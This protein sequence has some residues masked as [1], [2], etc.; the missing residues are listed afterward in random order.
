AS[1]A[2]AIGALQYNE[3]TA[4][5]VISAGRAAGEPGRIDVNPAGA[6]VTIRNGALTTGPAIPVAVLIRPSPRGPYLDVR[7]TGPLNGVR[8]VRNVS[9]ENPTVYFANAMRR[10]LAANGIE[11]EGATVDV[12][13]LPAPIAVDGL[14]PLLVHQSAPLVNLAA[15]M[16]KMSQNLYAETLLRTLGVHD[17]GVGSFE[18]GRAA[19]QRTLAAWGISP[20]DLMI[21]DGSGLSRHNLM[22]AEALVTVLARLAADE[23]LRDRFTAALPV[24]GRDGT[25]SDRMRHTAAEG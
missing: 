6:P 25:L 22:T 14:Q 20:S 15:T 9:V 10:A 12:D 23:R 13:D 19:L 18:T 16:M 2:T 5:L 21:A 1:Y 4:Q 11:V 17:T 8:H 3:N 7:G 24:A